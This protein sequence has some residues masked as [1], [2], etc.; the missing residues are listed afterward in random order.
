M[1]EA[2]ELVTDLNSD[3]RVV[4]LPIAPWRRAKVWSLQQRVAHCV[5]GDFWEGRGLARTAEKLRELVRGR[6]GPVDPLAAAVLAA[7][8]VRVDIPAAVKP[9]RRVP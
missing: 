6:A 5:A 7:L 4:T 1:S 9:K 8:P 2:V 3:F